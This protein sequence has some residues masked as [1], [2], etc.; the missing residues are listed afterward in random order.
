MDK[1]FLVTKH[2]TLITSSYDLTLEEQR[3][4]LTLASMV[5]PTDEDFKSYNF[6]IKKFME[7]LNVKD[8][9]KYILIPKITEGLMKKVF[10]IKKSEKKFTQLAWLSS[11]DYEKDS[12]IVSLEFSP[13]LK[14]YMLGL[15]EFYTSYRLANVLELKGKYSIRIY[16]ILKSNEYKKTLKIKVDELRE[17]LKADTGSYLVYQN[18]KNR[19]IINAQ[20]E[21]EK[22]TDISFE[23]EEKKLG[24]KV[25]TLI[26]TI[27]SKEVKEKKEKVEKPKYE[28]KNNTGS[29]GDYKQRTYD[30][31]KLERQLLGWDK[32]E[33]E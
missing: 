22:L 28:K 21:L 18:F 10:R 1:N 33:N 12:G 16:E 24:R 32:I 5:Q 23:F 15:K 17:I 25:D 8:E 7:L 27:K 3:V 29:F 4:I 2:N 6:E 30:F 20:N 31:D 9:N 11:A 14:P 19:I 26:F 13:K